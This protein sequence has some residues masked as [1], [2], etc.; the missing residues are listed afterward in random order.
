[1]KIT[2]EYSAQIRHAIGLSEETISLEDSQ[3]L[4]DLILLVL[5]LDLILLQKLIL[6]LL[7]LCE[8]TRTAARECIESACSVRAQADGA[9]AVM[10]R[11]EIISRPRLSRAWELDVA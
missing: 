5:L 9:F 10:Q 3:L 11:G 6:V 4:H 1:M 7:E 8:W 2:I